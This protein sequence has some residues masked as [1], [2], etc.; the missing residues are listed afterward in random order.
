MHALY[1]LSDDLMV[2][3]VYTLE[4]KCSLAL[5]YFLADAILSSFLY[6]ST[7]PKM[8][9]SFL[10]HFS[11]TSND[12]QL[13][14]YD[15]NINCQRRS[16]K[17]KIPLMIKNQELLKE[18]IHS[19]EFNLFH[20]ASPD[21]ERL[22]VAQSSTHSRDTST[23]NSSDLN[24]LNLV[25]PDFEKIFSNYND[26]DFG[27]K[28]D[29]NRARSVQTQH[30]VYTKTFVDALQKIQQREDATKYSITTNIERSHDKK[31]LTSEYQK[32]PHQIGQNT[33]ISSNV[34]TSTSIP[35]QSSQDMKINLPVYGRVVNTSLEDRNKNKIR[36]MDSLRDGNRNTIRPNHSGNYPDNQRSDNLGNGNTLVHSS[37]ANSN[38]V[39]ADF[40]NQT[41]SRN[42]IISNLNPE[43]NLDSHPELFK[44]HAH[45]K[46]SE[47]PKDYVE[48]LPPGHQVETSP[49]MFPLPPI[50]LQVQEIVKRERKKQK[51]RVAA[52]KCRKKKLEREANL[53]VRVQQLRERN[54][55]LSSIAS[56]LKNQLNDL[57]QHVMEHM[58]CGCH[59]TAY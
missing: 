32:I 2:Q 16:T 6:L 18:N 42:T 11:N 49:Q 28:D 53:E 43:L 4:K 3:T 20:M 54:I 23:I 46:F 13:L 24:V 10:S 21:L 31:I 5:K 45:V 37:V 12:H 52:S 27:Q 58:A 50:D 26:K 19:P 36:I 56:T 9:E 47:S 14:Y 1:T 15:G 51:N 40:V 39:N 30:D 55:E 8:E 44:L 38:I 41:V 35:N 59:V 29:L 25:S 57:K 34:R 33:T 48:K 17:D 22:I 7:F